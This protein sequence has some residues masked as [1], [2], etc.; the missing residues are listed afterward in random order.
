MLIS[1]HDYHK[2]STGDKKIKSAN[3][4]KKAR[5]NL[6]TGIQIIRNVHVHTSTLSKSELS[7]MFSQ[8]L[9]F[10]RYSYGDTIY[11]TNG[12]VTLSPDHL[13]L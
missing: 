6:R 10:S 7:A 13:G 2:I 5:E 4:L 9:C 12:N 1:Q 3:Q 11:I 8:K